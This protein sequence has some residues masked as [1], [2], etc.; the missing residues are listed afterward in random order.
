MYVSGWWLNPYPSEKYEFVNCYP[1]VNQHAHIAMESP[2]LIYLS[3]L[4]ITI[5]NGYVINYQ[6]VYGG[7]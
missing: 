7:S 6:S 3:S 1:L 5:F 4:K 2:I